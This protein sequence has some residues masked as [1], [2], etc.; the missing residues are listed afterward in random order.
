MICLRVGRLFQN[1]KESPMT[2]RTFDV[3]A[4]FEGYRNA[5]APVL[6]AQQE[7]MKSV[8]RLA[9]YQ[10]GVAGDYL[11]WS[12]AHSKATVAAK[13]AAEMVGQHTDINTRLSEQLK[14]RVQEFASIA[15]ETQGTVSQWLGEATAKVAEATKKAA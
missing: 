9:R 12:I 4:M 11:D 3:N 10:F 14:K 1:L 2:D 13:S 5:F 6:R 15:S 8:E 7:A